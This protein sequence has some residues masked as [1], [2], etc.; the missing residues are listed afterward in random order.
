MPK[1][2][3]DYSKT[4]LYKIVCRDLNVKD[5]YVGHTTDF[6]RRKTQHKHRCNT[7]TDKSYH[8]NLYQSI[9]NNGGWD[10]WEMVLYEKVECVDNLEARKRERECIEL[11]NANLNMYKSFT[12]KEEV[13]ESRK[14]YNQEYR[15]THKIEL[16]EYKKNTTKFIMKKTNYEY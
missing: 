13:R 7:Q 1:N 15:E 6:N 5:C 8:L 12:T 9:R 16:K 3:I 2:K 4:L 11:L 10:N 14:G